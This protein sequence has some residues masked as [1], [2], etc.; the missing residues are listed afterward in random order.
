MPF[1]TMPDPAA[2]REDDAARRHPDRETLKL[3]AA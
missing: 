1:P 2:D 3:A